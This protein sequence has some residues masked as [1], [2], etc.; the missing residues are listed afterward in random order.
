MLEAD[1]ELAGWLAGWLEK[2][3]MVNVLVFISRR[4]KYEDTFI[5]H[6]FSILAL[7]TCWTR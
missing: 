7:L 4:I 6:G 5:A 2:A 1:M 3:E